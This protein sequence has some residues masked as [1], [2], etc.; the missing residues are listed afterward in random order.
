MKRTLLVLLLIISAKLSFSQAYEARIKV[1]IPEGTTVRKVD[2]A[3]NCPQKILKNSILKSEYSKTKD[4]RTYTISKL[5]TIRRDTFY[6]F[7]KKNIIKIKDFSG[8]VSIKEDKKDKSKLHLNPWLSKKKVIPSKAIVERIERKVDCSGNYSL[9]STTRDTLDKNESYRYL[10]KMS[11]GQDQ[12]TLFTKTDWYE[13][14][15]NVLKVYKKDSELDFYLINKYD[16]NTDFYLKLENRQFLSLKRESYVFG[17]ITIPFKYR[18]AHKKNDID[19]DSEFSTDFN[20]GIFGG[21]NWGRYRVRYESKE[22]K[23]LSNLS[24]TLGGF[25]SL[26]RVVLDS[27]STTGAKMHLEEGEKKA[28]ATLS[29]GIG[30]MLSIYNFN[31]G[32]FGGIDAGFGTSAKKWDYNYRPWFGVGIG[33]NTAS[34]FFKK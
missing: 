6:A 9:A 29:P 13:K 26:S 2:N 30:V 8:W 10:K 19:I 1:Y 34:S 4:G 28:I 11:K 33:Y 22:L 21:K 18:F 32:F 14:S 5:D 7:D 31:F 25:L 17:P 3:K 15:K 12:D 20:V 16:Q 23:K 24:R 27:S